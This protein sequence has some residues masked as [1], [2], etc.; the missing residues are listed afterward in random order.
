MHIV[1]GIGDVKGLVRDETSRRAR[2]AT[3]WPSS[4]ARASRQYTCYDRDIA[5]RAQVWLHEEA[6][7]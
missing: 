1:D 2:A 7:K 6:P 5:A 4:P 3:R